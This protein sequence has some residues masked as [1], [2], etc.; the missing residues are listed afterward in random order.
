M[1]HRKW[2]ANKQ[3]PGTAEPGNMLGCCLN[4][5]H[6]LWA[7]LITSTVHSLF[8][9]RDIG[10]FCPALSLIFSK[11]L[12]RN[13]PYLSLIFLKILLANALNSPKHSCP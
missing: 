12:H 13:V 4:Y 10:F 1:A 5:F 6:F 2:K 3:E 7:I 11:I 9:I 8:F